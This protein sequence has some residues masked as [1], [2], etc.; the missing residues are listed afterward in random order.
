MKKY[1]LI[2]A[3]GGFA[4]A[5]AALAAARQGIS[6][7]LID[8]SG[9]LGGAATNCLVTPFMRYFTTDGNG[10][11]LYLSRG[12]FEELV[13]A[14]KA[15]ETRETGR[16]FSEEDL[17]LILNRKLLEAKADILF[18]S[19][20]FGVEKDGNN[21][22]AVKV[23]NKTGIE[24]YEA[25]FFIDATGDADLAVFAGCPTRLGREKD[26][27]CQPM[28]LNFRVGGVD[29]EAYAKEKDQITPL[30][31]KLQ[32][33]GKIKNI[34]ENVLVFIY[35]N[36]D[37]VLHFN[38]TRVVKR[39]PVNAVDVSIAE[40]E[41]REQVDEMM[42]FLK[43][44][45]SAFKNSYLMMT[46]AEIGVRESRMIDGEYILNVQDLY[47][48]KKFEDKIAACDY[49]IDIHNPEGSGTSHHFFEKGTYYTIPYRSLI[50]KNA[51]NLL[52]AGR[53]ISSDHEAQASYR[54]M[55]TVSTL[56]EAAGVAASIAVKDGTTNKG[57]DV[58]KLQAVLTETGAFIG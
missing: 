27:L 16:Y 38:T 56:G 20:V 36:I 49:D 51:D 52:V 1:D 17:K 32:N 57:V 3:G 29:M 58:K 50:P 6:V 23:V 33:E 53:C 31:N 34:R 13:A 48:C 54:I 40:I 12:I 11:P 2:V 15:R 43:A 19:Y 25:K 9:A 45:F 4:G 37:G 55:P 44:N 14:M 28:T 41:A 8:K 24:T 47:D 26:N 5:S 39:N 21:I 42:S 22:T 7:L 18:H 10:Q 30:Y 35:P 46:A